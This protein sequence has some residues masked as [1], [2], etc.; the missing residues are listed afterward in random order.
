MSSRSVPLGRALAATS[1][2]PNSTQQSV[3][4]LK[5]SRTATCIEI[6]FPGSGKSRTPPTVSRVVFLGTSSATPTPARNTSAV[7]VTL[8]SGSTVL[9]DCG[10]ATQHRLLHTKTVRMGKIDL[11]LITHLHGDHCF[12]LFGLLSTMALNGRD[13]ENPVTVVGPAGIR[14]MLT[15]VADVSASYFG[16]VRVV[17]LPSDRS[18]HA[19][20]LALP[21]GLVVHARRIPHVPQLATWGYV[22]REPEMPGRLDGR[23][24]ASLG[25]SG[26][27]LRQLKEGKD[28]TLADGRVVQSRRVVSAPR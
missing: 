3:D 22:F 8:S 2:A 21:G 10:E 9:V 13:E 14:R 16:H 15:V 26:P 24:A 7:A 28:V 25:A 18:V 4:D 19:V 27:Q 12:G 6:D 23:L 1:A 5:R 11:V 20:D 17:E